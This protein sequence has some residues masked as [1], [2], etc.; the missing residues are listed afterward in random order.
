KPI[1]YK[2]R[3][4]I[5]SRKPLAAIAQILAKLTYYLLCS[6]FFCFHHRG[7]TQGKG[8]L[9]YQREKGTGNR[10]QGTESREKGTKILTIP[11]RIG[12]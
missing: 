5:T 9:L 8:F 3:S 10:E 11:T 1:R 6:E 2:T 12:I 7:G 4:R